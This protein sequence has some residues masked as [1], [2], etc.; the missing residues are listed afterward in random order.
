MSSDQ[1]YVFN[2]DPR[3]R[4]QAAEELLDEGTTRLL[5]QLGVGPGWQ[6]LE[7]GAGGGSIARWLASVVGPGGKVI[8]TDVDVRALS[9]MHESNVEVRQ[10]DLVQD[11]LEEGRYDLVH[12]RLLL[13]HLAD[14]E[15]ALAKL[16]GAVRGGGWMM[17]E[18]VD[19]VSG[20]PVSLLG[21]AEHEKT[22]SVRLRHFARFGVDPYLGRY[23]PGQLRAN[24][25][26]R[27]GNEGRV[28]VMEGGSPGARWF[29]LSLDHLRSPLTGPDLLT[30]AEIDRMLALFDDPA[31]AAFSPI[32]MAA[33]GQRPS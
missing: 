22:Q 7:V 4:L 6:C 3:A 13:E 23:L 28:W 30:D 1:H 14:R 17:V 19:Y 11:P 10:H 31:W 25:L 27:I 8:A 12:A 2:A 18:D 26:E 24:G 9:P 5:T 33:W 15:R 20:I 32:V 21:A 16:V 29:K